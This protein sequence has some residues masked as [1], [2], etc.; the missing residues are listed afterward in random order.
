[1]YFRQQRVKQTQPLPDLGPSSGIWWLI[2]KLYGPVPRGD[3]KWILPLA[4]GTGVAIAT[5][6]SLTEHL[7]LRTTGVERAR[8]LNG[9][10]P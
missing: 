10:Q 6:H 3:L 2:K 7:F 1:M 4:V 8:E 5:D 9:S